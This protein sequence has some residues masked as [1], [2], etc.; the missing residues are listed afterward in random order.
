MLITA[1][2]TNAAVLSSLP[3]LSI[4]K[5]SSKNP[6]RIDERFFFTLNR[7][8]LPVVAKS[9][10]G[11]GILQGILEESLSKFSKDPSQGIPQ[12]SIW[13]LLHW[14]SCSFWLLE[15]VHLAPES[16]KESWTNLEPISNQ[17][18]TNPESPGLILKVLNQ[19]WKSWT[20]PESP[21]SILKVLNQSW[22]SWTNLESPEP[23]LNQS[24]KS[25]TNPEPILKVLKVLNQNGGNKS[26]EKC[27]V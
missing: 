10:A 18:R 23:I 12:G 19:S 17:S 4:L 14:I 24:W 8:E 26:I 25:W 1:V 20:N 2:V 9:P 6:P 11:P 16:I 15:R 5:E 27:C 13:G 21:E 3:T 7:L 22:K